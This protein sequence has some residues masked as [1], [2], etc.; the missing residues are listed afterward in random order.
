MNFPLT[1]QGPYPIFCRGHS[2]GRMVCEAFI[3]NSIAMG[4]VSADKKDTSFFAIDNPMVRELIEFSFQYLQANPEER[5]PWQDRMRRCLEIYYDSDISDPGPFGWKMGISLFM[6]PLVL[7][8]FPSAKVVHLIRDGRDVMLSR[9][10]A[11]LGGNNLEDP[12]NRMVVFGSPDVTTW[13][14]RPL[15]PETVARHRNALEMQHWV[16]AV[17][18]GLQGRAWPDRYL[19][20]YYEKIC[21]YPEAEFERIFRFLNLPFQDAARAWVQAAAHTG[22]IGKWKGLPDAEISE[23]LHIGRPLLAELGY[24]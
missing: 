7:D 14:G 6:M 23:A 20:V 17:R 16:T 19:E 24:I 3:R 21:R 5:K 4:K 12:V 9:L 8:T 22:R 18:Y 13:A 2:G 10:D 11:R 15:T 1:M